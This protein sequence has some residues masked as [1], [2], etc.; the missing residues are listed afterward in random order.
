MASVH[1]VGAMNQACAKAWGHGLHGWVAGSE[2]LHAS[3]LSW[4][5]FL[6]CLGQMLTWQIQEL[7]AGQGL[8]EPEPAFGIPTL[9]LLWQEK[10]V[11]GKGREAS[12]IYQAAPGTHAPAPHSVFHKGS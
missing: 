10:Q 2:V 9:G 6:I 5:D 8:G 12:L 11:T 4:G 1:G 7:G 3:C